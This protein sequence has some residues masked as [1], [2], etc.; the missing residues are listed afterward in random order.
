[1]EPWVVVEEVVDAGNTSVLRVLAMLLEPR[2]NPLER[3]RE[4]R[5]EIPLIMTRESLSFVSV[6]SIVAAAMAGTSPLNI[7]SII[8]LSVPYNCIFLWPSITRLTRN[9]L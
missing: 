9:F 7:K 3:G 2:E 6:N 1:M 8:A 4:K 5:R